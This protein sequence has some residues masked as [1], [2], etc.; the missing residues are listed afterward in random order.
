MWTSSELHPKKHGGSFGFQCNV[1]NGGGGGEECEPDDKC[2]NPGAHPPFPAWEGVLATEIGELGNT[3]GEDFCS[4]AADLEMRSITSSS[5]A[6]AF[7]DFEIV[8][9]ATIFFSKL[10]IAP[11]WARACANCYCIT[12][13]TSSLIRAASPKEISVPLYCS[14]S[15]MEFSCSLTVG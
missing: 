2:E 4:E 13:C 8:S 11:V 7:T 15:C 3:D 9:F 10:E 12:P 14:A 6:V 1:A 5:S